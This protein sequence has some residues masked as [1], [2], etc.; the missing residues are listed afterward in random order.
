MRIAKIP[1]R[2]IQEIQSQSNDPFYIY[3]IDAIKQ[4]VNLMQNA[5][6]KVLNFK[7][8]YAVK[9]NPN[10]QILKEILNGGMGMDCS[11]Y[12]DLKLAQ[13]IGAKGEQIIFT[14]NNTPLE[15]FELALEL[16]AIINFDD[17]THIPYLFENLNKAPN[18]ACCRYNPGD[19]KTGNSIIGNPLEAKYGMTKDQLIQ[20][21]KVL[22]E[23]GCTR[24]GIHTMVA[25]NELSLDY[26][27]QTAQIMFQTAIDIQKELGI[28]FEFIN[29]GGGIG[30]PYHPNQTPIDFQDLAN[31]ISNVY[32]DYFSSDSYLPK[33]NM[34]C[35]RFVTGPYGYLVT[36]VRHIKRTYKNYAGV[37][38]SMADLMRPGMYLAHH[39][40]QVLGKENQDNLEIYDVTGNLCE[41]ND[42]FA[43]DRK[44][45]IL[46]VGDTLII[47]DVGAHGHCM[48]FNYNGLLR[49]AEY[50]YSESKHELKLIRRRQALE[51]L[52]ATH[53]Y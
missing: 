45:P 46:E 49:P 44:L 31:Q 35:G 43:I 10:P 29:L 24:F 12:T 25:S 36:K 50:T 3:D 7:N 1:S 26:F 28:Q 32:F 9:A 19:L 15:D 51:D 53:I 41:N 52:F 27:I 6:N 38:A 17:I 40:I 47:H 33:I 39:E 11:T 13:L 14:S 30:I 8:F 18:V 4:N 48:G 2:I 37:T 22:K 16:G 21:Y 20:S 23:K 34:E 5:F 42:K